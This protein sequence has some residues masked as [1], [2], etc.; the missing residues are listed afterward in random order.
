VTFCA[1]YDVSYSDADPGFGDDYITSDTAYPARGARIEVVKASTGTVV[2]DGYTLWDGPDAGCLPASIPLSCLQTYDVKVKSEASIRGNTL[3]VL[4]DDSLMGTFAYGPPSFWTGSSGTYTITTPLGASQWNIANAVG[5][6]MYRHSGGLSGETFEFFYQP[7][8]TVGGSG[9]E[10]G[11]DRVY[12]S[13]GEADDKVIIVHE[14]GHLL[15]A[16]AHWCGS[17]SCCDTSS[18]AANHNYDADLDNCYTDL[19][20]ADGAADTEV[21]HAGQVF[22]LPGGAV[23]PESIQLL[24][25]ID[26]ES[27]EANTGAGIAAP[28]LDGDGQLDLCVSAPLDDQVGTRAGR[29]GCFYGPVTGRHPLSSADIT[30]VAEDTY[31]F[32]GFSLAA[33][34]LE[35]DGDDELAIGVPDDPYFG[36]GW[37][38]KVYLFDPVTRGAEPVSILAGVP[39]DG[40]G[41][42]M[43]AG[44]I[45]GDGRDDLALGAPW[46][47][48]GGTMR[49]SAYLLL[50]GSEAW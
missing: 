3:V 31:A 23:V 18:C 6:A 24:D 14:F 17:P 9:Y 29:V 46:A 16:R 45:D 12:I 19:I 1:Q 47:D 37:P 2:Y 22:I 20:V 25:G 26:G 10:R 32:F 13:S 48:G 8:P 15:A 38:G 28:D 5:H 40:L 44:D 27:E 21:V 43:A 41:I 11:D 34:D 35:G 39:F 36:H 4:D 49:G 42:D 7:Y 33:L 30:F 50:G